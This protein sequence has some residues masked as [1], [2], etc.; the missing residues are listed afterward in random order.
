[1]IVG[2]AMLDVI[3]EPAGEVRELDH[4]EAAVSFVAGGSGVNLALAAIDAGFTPV[5]LVC[6]LGPEVYANRIIRDELR[7]AGVELIVN[8]VLDQPTG[9]AVVGYL[10]DG[11]RI[12][13]GSPGANGAPLANQTIL[14]V[15]GIMPDVVVVSGYM[16]FRPSTRESVLAIMRQA[17]RRGVVV[18]LDLVPHSIHRQISP[19]EFRNLLSLVNFVAAE[20][21]TLIAFGETI[22]DL[23]TEVEGALEYQVGVRFRAVN[24]NGLC[25]DGEFSHPSHPRDLR[26]MTDRLLMSVLRE[27]FLT[28][29]GDDA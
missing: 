19:F 7:T 2:D 1:M 13:F 17:S 24:R 9:V 14:A 25:V 5:S 6:S 20:R 21:N 22:D 23:L 15:C 16:L 26:G 11:S 8:S 12:M 18:V 10:A 29:P 4:I 3:A 27:H 28:L